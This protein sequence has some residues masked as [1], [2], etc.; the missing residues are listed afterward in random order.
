MCITND[1]V[2]AFRDSIIARIVLIIH[3]NVDFTGD[4]RESCN[5]QYN[6]QLCWLYS[7]KHNTHFVWAFILLNTPCEGSLK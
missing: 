2:Q 7:H 5:V 6:E 4:E 3:N 1:R